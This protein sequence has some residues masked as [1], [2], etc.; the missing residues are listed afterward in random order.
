MVGVV[1]C[2]YSISG[3]VPEVAITGNRSI[4]VQKINKL[5]TT[6]LLRITGSRTTAKL[7]G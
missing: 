5:Q 1:D 6:L 3:G 7:V 2:L 4:R